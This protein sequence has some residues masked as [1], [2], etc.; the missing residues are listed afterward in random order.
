V[1]AP[2]ARPERCRPPGARAS[3]DRHEHGDDPDARGGHAA[4][5]HEEAV[6][7]RLQAVL[8]AVDPPVEP[9]LDVI[10]PAV[11][12]QNLLAQ[13]GLGDEL[14]EAGVAALLEEATMASGCA[15]DR[16]AA[17][18]SFTARCVSSTPV[19]GAPTTSDLIACRLS[20]RR[21]S[22]VPGLAPGGYDGPDR[23]RSRIFGPCAMTAYAPLFQ[24]GPDTTEYRPLD[25]AGVRPLELGDRRFLEVA[26]E[27]LA[28]LA[29]QA[30]ADVEHLFR[31]S[32]LAQLRAIL[33]DPEA[34]ANDR[35][36]A[37]E[38]LKNAVIAAGRRFPS[39]QDTGT[40][41]VLGKKGQEVLTAG[42][43]A[44]ALSAGIE[45]V[46]RTRNLRF[47]H[48][49]PLSM[50]EERNTGTNLPA[51]I[52]IMAEPGRAYDFLFVAKGGGSA[53]KTYLFQETRRILEPERLAAFFDEK[54]RTLGTAACPPYHLAIVIGGLSA[55]Q[56]LKTVKLASCRY[57]DGL[58]GE[59]DESGRA[60]RDRAFEE[61]I[62][63]ITR[64]M[65]TGAQFGGKYFCHDVRVIRLPRHNGSLPVG[66]G[67]SCS[68][69]RQVK[70]KI[71]ED[72]VFLERL[73]T[74]PARYLP[75]AEVEIGGATHIDLTRPMAEITAELSKLPVTAPVLLSG[76]LVVAR[77]LV[78]AELAKRQ[79]DGLPLPRYVRDHPIYYAG[80][81]KT[82][83]GFASGSFGPT[84]AARMDPYVPELQA[85]GASLVTLAKG[86]RSREVV[87]SCWQ[88][89]GFYLATIGGAAARVG[90]D[91][92]RKVE[93]IDFPEF[94]MEAVWRIEV[95]DLPAFIV[96]DD[97]GND[98]YARRG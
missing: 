96:I 16:L 72:G 84:T 62:L 8:K 87:K 58:P 42:D 67:V 61:T 86:N 85:E 51:Q 94:G 65:S 2:R 50:Y 21:G 49:A 14:R 79:R 44:A 95:E 30:F 45:E 28:G 22:Q 17:V 3:E 71:T 55:E 12:L 27:T 38:L 43:D 82:P 89:G 57:L 24:L 90:R 70:A 66:L 80:P 36:V 78:H 10:Y 41:I 73:E 53:N 37:M 35:F 60:F 26:P 13:I 5:A 20:Q 25:L 54:I 64:A 18:S 56:T 52:E 6:L 19:I 7:H 31:P 23:G 76:P 77:D 88:H 11:E 47:S 48:L 34:T 59:G 75:E 15:S 9:L 1:T 69:D 81:A 97:K 93:V 33:D 92:I 83:E 4:E 63:E 40:A 68:A 29:E 32:H 98:F 91:M 39:C 46:W 74:D